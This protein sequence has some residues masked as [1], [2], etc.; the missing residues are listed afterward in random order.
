MLLIINLFVLSLTGCDD[1]DDDTSATQESITNEE[2]VEL[3]E[4]SDASDEYF[5]GPR[6]VEFREQVYNREIEFGILDIDEDG[7]LS[8]S[9]YNGPWKMFQE[10]DTNGDNELS[11]DE[12]KYMMTFSDIPEGSFIM[13]SDVPIQA[14]FEPATDSGP[15]HQVNIDGFKMSAT[16]VTTAQYTL[17]LNSALEAGEIEVKL[18]TVSGPQTRLYYP[19]PAYVVEGAVGTEYAGLPYIHLSPVGPLSHTQ[20]EN[21]P[22]LIPEHP[23]N[24]SWIEY[25]PELNKFYTRL[26]FEDWPAVHIK[27]W[28][29]MAFANHYDLSI[30]TEAEWEYAASGG[31]NNQ[32]KFATSDGSNGCQRANYKCYNVEQLPYFEGADTPDEYIGFRM[33]VGSYPPN[34]YGIYDLAGNIWEW[35]LDWYSDHFYQDIV[36]N[37]IISNPVNLEGEEAP[38][39][40][41]ATGGPGQD[42]SHDA[43][44]TR[45]GSYNYHEPVT[46][47]AYRFPVYSFIGN[48]H[49]G[50]RVVERSPTVVFNGTE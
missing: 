8:D 27:W 28:G 29:A 42:F 6:E 36:D 20:A 30:P 26:G 11:L 39:D 37:G 4:P 10:M 13:G 31:A 46:R 45:G 12:A 19:V 24:I 48:D 15:A 22:L 33:T 1:D 41:S 3:A 47:T 35:N 18:D 17:Y 16:E 25:V 44:V 43:R 14:F 21:S 2:V 50:M 32:F 9:E 49:F 38:M 34:P 5:P 7:F 40:G 23:L